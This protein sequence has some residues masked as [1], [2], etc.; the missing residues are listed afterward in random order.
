MDDVKKKKEK[1][2]GKRPNEMFYADESDDYI[3]RKYINCVKVMSSERI[4]SRV[5]FQELQ[6]ID[7]ISAS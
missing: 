5:E 3:L 7:S 2:K 6:K 4:V 1:G